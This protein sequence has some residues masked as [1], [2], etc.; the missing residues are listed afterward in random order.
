MWLGETNKLQSRVGGKAEGISRPTNIRWQSPQRKQTGHT[1]LSL[2]SAGNAKN[3]RQEEFPPL[4]LK[5]WL[6]VLWPCS[7]HHLDQ[8][9]VAAATVAESTHKPAASWKGSGGGWPRLNLAW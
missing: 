9:L 2:V 3:K 7:C 1:Q 8:I 5:S 4:K 6:K